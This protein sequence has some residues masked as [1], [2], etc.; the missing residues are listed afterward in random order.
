MAKVIDLE[1][2]LLKGWDD[3]LF[4]QQ[5][6]PATSRELAA[7]E[8]H[9]QVE[10]DLGHLQD[11]LILVDIHNGSISDPESSLWLLTEVILDL[12][13]IELKRVKKFVKTLRKH[14]AHLLTFL[15]WTETALKGYETQLAPLIPDDNARQQFIQAVARSWRL[16]Q[17]LING[18][19]QWQTQ[20]LLAQ[21][22]LQAVTAT[23]PHLA[24]AALALRHLLDASGRTS[25]L[26][27]SL[28]SLLK[29]FFRNRKGFKDQETMQAYLN[30]FVLWHNMRVYDPR[31]KRGGQ[32]PFQL[33]GI[34]LGSDD[35][36]S[37]LGFSP[38]S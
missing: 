32:S 10:R 29:S 6:L 25:S 35:W 1:K 22:L 30:L 16:D 23:E 26:I 18:H 5:Y 33:A 38:A 9:D 7:I 24:Q 21:T 31:S 20:A 14:Q 11:A 8:S 3:D 2:K 4:E 36:L 34:D 28:N 27:E 12:A 37:L 13:Q 15:T 19:R 17:A